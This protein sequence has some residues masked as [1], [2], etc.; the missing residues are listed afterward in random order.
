MTAAKICGIGDTA[1]L[2]AAVEGGARW[3]GLVFFPK[4]PRFVSLEKAA[5][6]AHRAHGRVDIVAVTVNLGPAELQ[7][8]AKAVRPDWIQLH[9]SE[10]PDAAR[11][12][13]PLARKGIIKAVSVAGAAD[14]EGLAPWTDACDWLLFDAKAPAGAAMPGGNGAAFDWRLL[15]GRTIPRPWLLSGGLTAGNV[16]QA[17]DESGAIAVDVS[18]GVESGPGVKDP[19]RIAAFLAA[20]KTS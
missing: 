7:T 6:L 11:A 19:E 12:A 8:I 20:A 15:R 2:D 4:S 18:S 14:F 16:A 13:R 1:G 9:G 10:P 3:I 5:S 17:L